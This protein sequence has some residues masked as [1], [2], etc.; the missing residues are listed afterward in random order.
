[1]KTENQLY[2]NEIRGDARIILLM[3][4]NSPDRYS[5][6]IPL[7]ARTTSSRLGLLK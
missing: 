7:I 4:V 5:C 6:I 1:M 2:E 3:I